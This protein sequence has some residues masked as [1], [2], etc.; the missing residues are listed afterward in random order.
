VDGLTRHSCILAGLMSLRIK[1]YHLNHHCWVEFS[2][3]IALAVP[4]ASKKDVCDNLRISDKQ[5]AT[6]VNMS[7][8]HLRRPCSMNKV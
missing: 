2:W 3:N 7:L 4:P 8:G 6:H 1:P 5:L